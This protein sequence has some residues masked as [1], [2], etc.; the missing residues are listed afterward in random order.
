MSTFLFEP[1]NETDED[2]DDL[3]DETIIDFNSDFDRNISDDSTDMN[4]RPASKTATK[5]LENVKADNGE[6]LSKIGSLRCLV[7]LEELLNETD[8]RRLPCAHVYHAGCIIQMLENGN[9]CPLCRHKLPVVDFDLNLDMY[10][11]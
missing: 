7:C 2:Y 10:S 9:M 1:F 3:E 5:G 4:V 11:C 6:E 8:G